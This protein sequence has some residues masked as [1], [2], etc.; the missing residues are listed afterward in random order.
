M[1]VYVRDA[2]RDLKAEVDEFARVME[3]LDTDEVKVSTKHL[4]CVAQRL[5]NASLRL[6]DWEK[7]KRLMMQ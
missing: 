7:N 1:N 5:R 2:T 4:V 3:T 6:S